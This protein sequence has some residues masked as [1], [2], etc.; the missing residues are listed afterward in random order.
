MAKKDRAPSAPTTTSKSGKHRYDRTSIARGRKSDLKHRSNPTT[1]KGN[2]RK[3]CGDCRKGKIKIGKKTITF[4]KGALHRALGFS[5]KFT[6]SEMARMNKVAVGKSFKFKG[7]THK[8]TT[9]MKRRVSFG[10]TLMGFK[11]R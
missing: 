8:M 9:L 5:G 1:K 6:K 7:K 3:G 2:K 4:K 11:K 10:K